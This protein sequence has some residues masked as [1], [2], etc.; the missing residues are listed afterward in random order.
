MSDKRRYEAHE[1]GRSRQTL[2]KLW[3]TAR[4]LTAR[5]RPDEDARQAQTAEPAPPIEP[6]PPLPPH[7]GPVRPAPPETF[8]TPEAMWRAW[9]AIRAA[10]GGAGVDG[11]TL[12]QFAERAE[13]EL[14][15]LRRELVTGTYRPREVR[16]VLVPK[17]KEGLRPL[18]LWC[19]RDRIA[20]RV[21]YDIIAPSF[22]AIFLPSSFGFRPGL[23]TA[24]AA[25]QVAAY[26]DQG[27]QWVVDA[28]IE[29]CFDSIPP[30]PLLE[31]VRR[32]VHDRHLLRLIRAWLE[33]RI[34]NT[35]SGLPAAA[36]VAQGGVLS[37]LLAN[38]YLHEFDRALAQRRLALVRYADDW[39]VCCRRRVMAEAALT[40]CEQE[41]ERLSLRL[42]KHKTRIVHFDQGFKFVGYF[43][44]GCKMYRL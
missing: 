39:V 19:L 4:R 40:L 21:V 20:Q 17:R 8:F 41:L 38:V 3:D 10:G 30:K 12:A 16:Q 33:A 31:L 29:S 13:T 32:R 44:I 37:P 25:A 6:P 15:Q 36:V 9:R 18:A 11:Q 5:R 2:A 1:S 34:L 22:E 27:L 7:A 42:N 26:R 28:D 24:D 35:A 14:E 43:F 23:S